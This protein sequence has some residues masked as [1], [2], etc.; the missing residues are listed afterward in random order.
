MKFQRVFSQMNL[1]ESDEMFNK[2]STLH[3][4]LRMSQNVQY[5]EKTFIVKVNPPDNNH[6]LKY[7]TIIFKNEILT[8]PTKGRIKNHQNRWQC[9]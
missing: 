1:R 6:E 3:L 8:L 5:E 7:I 9:A 4:T 2:L